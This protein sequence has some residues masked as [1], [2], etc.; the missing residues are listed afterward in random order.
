[1]GLVMSGAELGCGRVCKKLIAPLPVWTIDRAM[2]QA[3]LVAESSP[4][5]SRFACSA[6]WSRQHTPT[7]PGAA[8][9]GLVSYLSGGLLYGREVKRPGWWVASVAGGHA[10]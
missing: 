4:V 5:R 9:N 8:W 1:M 10:L 3:G 7:G 6:C 2:G